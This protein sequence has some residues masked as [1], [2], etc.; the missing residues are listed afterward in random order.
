MV[1]SGP[2]VLL[3]CE[4][5]LITPFTTGLVAARMKLKRSGSGSHPVPYSA[6]VRAPLIRSRGCQISSM[7]KK[8]TSASK[9]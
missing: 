7:G 3:R 5:A 9:L 6:L 4:V 2:R 8:I 1:N